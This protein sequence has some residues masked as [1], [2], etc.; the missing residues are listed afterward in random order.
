M[1]NFII[2]GGAL[3]GLFVVVA[4]VV[5]VE[6]FAGY[7]LDDF[8]KIASDVSCGV[9]AVETKTDPVLKLD[10]DGREASTTNPA[11]IVSYL[12][13]PGPITCSLYKTG[14]VVCDPRKKT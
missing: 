14:S 4:I 12:Q 5:A 11:V 9:K 7:V 2:P 10:C 1:K 6:A 8:T 3:F 13:N